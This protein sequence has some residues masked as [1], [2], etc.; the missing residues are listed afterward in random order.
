MLLIRLAEKFGLSRI[1]FRVP[2]H[3]LALR[4]VTSGRISY[5]ALESH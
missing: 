3:S 4:R 2:P 1:V 5:A